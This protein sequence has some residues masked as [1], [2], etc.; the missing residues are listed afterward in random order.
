[1]TPLRLAGGFPKSVG[2]RSNDCLGQFR[3]VY[4]PSQL[5]GR[6]I[7]FDFLDG[8]RFRIQRQRVKTLELSLRPEPDLPLINFR[9]VLNAGKAISFGLLELEFVGPLAP[10]PEPV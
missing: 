7:S 10:D 6:F 4:F 2:S 9:F 8:H 3:H 1:V 5:F